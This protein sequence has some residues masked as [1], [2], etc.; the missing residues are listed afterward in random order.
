MATA[1]RRGSEDALYR[2][3]PSWPAPEEAPRRVRQRLVRAVIWFVLA[4]MPAELPWLRRQLIPP[5]A[6]VQDDDR[7]I[8]GVDEL[9]AGLPSAS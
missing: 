5:H 2:L 1:S 6:I 8:L 3:S 4:I 7:P 9:V